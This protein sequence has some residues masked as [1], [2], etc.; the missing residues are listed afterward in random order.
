M[1]CIF[2]KMVN[3][4]IPVNKIYEDDD[5]IAFNDINPEAPVHILIIPKEHIGSVLDINDTNSYLFSKIYIVANELA[6]K[7]ELAEK[8]FRIVTNCGDDGGQ[9]VKHLHFHLLG[10]RNF[11]WPP[12]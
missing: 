3:N 7:Y 11:G 4:E 5:I 6:R 10:G 2:C 1:D 9:S 8:G 12:G